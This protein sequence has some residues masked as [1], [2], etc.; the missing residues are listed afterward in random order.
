M[1]DLALREQIVATARALNARGINQGTAGN[2]S[3]RTSGGM[4]I[5]PSANSYEG[6]QPAD[7]VAMSLD[8]TVAHADPS[9]RPSSEWRMHAGVLRTRAHMNAVVH[10]HAMFATTLSCLRRGIPA[11]HYMVAAAGGTDIRCT[12]YA[13]VTTQELADRALEALEDRT[14][15]LL[16]NHGLLA[17]GTSLDAALALAVE[18]ETLAAQYWRVLQIGEPVLLSDEE[19]QR[20]LGKFV[21]YGSGRS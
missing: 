21:D 20:V 18:V 1:Q 10:A 15:C 9:V 3:V 12:E 11:F 19:M 17:C 5:T 7:V 16:A 13:T 14:A 4:L 8:G 6:L 2:V